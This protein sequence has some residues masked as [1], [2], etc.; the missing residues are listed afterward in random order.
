MLAV[1]MAGG[2]GTRLSQ[3]TKNEIPKPMVPVNGKP[4]LEWQLD[5][6]IKY[7]IDEVII[8]VGT[9]GEVIENHFGNHYSTIDISYIH[10][11]SPL[12]TAGAFYYLKDELSKRNADEFMFV[13]GDVFFNFDIE[14]MQHFHRMNN[15]MV[16]LLAHPNMHP[17]DSDLVVTDST[18]KV[19]GFDSKH[20]D[21]EN[22]FYDNCVNAGIYIINSSVTKLVTEPVKTDFEHNI[23]A[24]LVEE[25]Q[26]IYAYKTPEF[27]RDIGTVD[28]YEKTVKDIESGLVERK[29]LRNKQRAIFLDRDGVLTKYDGFIKHY[30]K[31]NL[32]TNSAEA[33][34]LIND[35]G[36]LA[37]LIT[38]QPV[39]ARGEVTFAQLEVLHNKM[40]TM[41]GKEGAFLD[42]IYVCP[43]HPD[44]GFPGEVPELKIECNCRKPKPG[45]LLAAAERYNIDL[46]QSWM[47]GDM[48]M[49]ILAGQNAGTH[50]A[51]VKTGHGGQDG[52]YKIQD[53]D[54][55][56]DDI[57][58][59]VQMIL[60]EY[61][62]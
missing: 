54:I 2:Q 22:Y 33:V 3:I 4:L 50:T 20:N 29:N 42:A 7:G 6:L 61:S 41:L 38:N 25:K 53:P 45:M 11:Q 47:I 12:G 17:Y 60:G 30:D 14:R 13:F 10:E 5:E 8:V 58:D 39:I 31:L 18:D 44:K 52:Y 21:R 34:R 51:L 26:D 59:A 15:A 9:L 28:R 62:I 27:I 1:I 16:T 37:I 57:L 40:K 49:D 32:E 55:I 35:S 24:K 19:I 23:L 43:H 36:C 56:A 48:T 46:S